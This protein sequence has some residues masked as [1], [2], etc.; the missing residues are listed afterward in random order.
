M[1]AHMKQL[2]K[3]SIGFSSEIGMVSEFKIAE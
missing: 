1:P 2:F 3:V